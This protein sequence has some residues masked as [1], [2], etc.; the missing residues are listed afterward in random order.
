[1]TSS[2]GPQ[3][4]SPAADSVV[5]LGR[6]FLG[7]ALSRRVIGRGTASLT[8]G[9]GEILA[10]THT[11]HAA[12]TAVLVS[13][14]G[15]GV[16]SFYE[17]LDSVDPLVDEAV[18]SLK[19]FADLTGAPRILHVSSG[20]AVYGEVAE[21]YFA[22]ETDALA[23]KSK[24]GHYHAKLE[25]KL[26]GSDLPGRL[27]VARLTN[28]YGPDQ[29][30]RRGQ[31]LVAHVIRSVQNDEPLHVFGNTTRDYVHIDDVTEGMWSLAE[32][33]VTG[34]VNV[35]SGGESSTTDVIE[36]VAKTLNKTPTLLVAERRPFDVQRSAVDV[37]IF[38]A[39]LARPPQQ[40]DEGIRSLLV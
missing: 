24:Y 27:V 12:R 28:P 8:L 5:I 33:E 20:G 13:A 35:G 6:G 36:L 4:P 38:T 19:R 16:P 18:E 32:S 21:G 2:S 40:I 39:T 34:P 29:P 37:S 17:E 10:G 7:E 31:G 25:E 11:A 23:P 15:R 9:Q 30:L 1:M 22:R 3:P 26:L 14:F